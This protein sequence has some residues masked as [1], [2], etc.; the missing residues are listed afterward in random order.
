MK[1]IKPH[2]YSAE[3][4]PELT[5]NNYEALKKDIKENGIRKP[6]D[7]APDGDILDGHHR[8]RIAQE[9]DFDLNEIPLNVLEE[10]QSEAEKKE[11]II[12]ANL[13]RRQLSTAQKYKLYA[14]LSKN[15]EV[16]QTRNKKG[17]FQSRDDTLSSRED[18][19]ERT[20]RGVG[21]SAKTIERARKYVKTIEKYPDL[22]K[23]GSSPLA[24]I[25]EGRRREKKEKREEKTEGLPKIKNL[26][27]GNCLEEIED[28][29]DN[30][31]DCVITDPP[32]GSGDL[33]GSREEIFELR[34]DWVYDGDDENIFPFLDV[35]F[36]RLKP[37]LKDDAHIYIFTIWK[38]WHKLYPIVDNHFKVRNWLGYLHYL[39][40][41]GQN[42]YTY[43][44]GLSS[45]L[46]AVK[47]GGRELQG[48]KW[49]F[50]DVQGTKTENK[51]HPAQKSLAIC[52]EL[53]KKS[54]LEG[55]TVLDP[56][57]G[58]GSTLV[59]AEKFNRNWIGIETEEKWYNIARSRIEE[60]KNES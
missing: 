13:V 34:T 41:T 19:N 56:F 7:V 24:L 49:N 53:I 9:L 15:Y 54:T 38:V 21:E 48:K 36:E 35:L 59:A 3:V 27:L 47:N 30:S 14:E 11:W 44:N 17:Q 2:P 4:M 42:V 16:G 25:Q 10:I 37:K 5:D 31:I 20:A 52:A 51:F 39:A 60:M 29:P 8:Y 23:P 22:D 57:A 40:S 6:L 55:E 28:I 50:F 33:G 32:Y 58:S 45:I 26:I 12:K 1:E 18:V 43:K 46:Y